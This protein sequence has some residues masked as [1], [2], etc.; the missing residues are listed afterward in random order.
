[1]KQ[2][3]LDLIRHSFLGWPIRLL[4]R[5]TWRH[6]RLL[7]LTNPFFLPSI[8]INREGTSLLAEPDSYLF[9]NSEKENYIRFRPGQ[10]EA[11]ITYLS[12]NLIEKTDIVLDIGANVGLHTVAFAREASQGHVYAFEPTTEMTERLSANVSLNGIKNVTIVPCALG[13]AEEELEMFINTSGAGLE[14][15]STITGTHNVDRNP[16]NYETR[17]V[18]VRRLDYLVEQ[19]GIKGRIGFIKID[20]EGYETWVIEGGLNTIRAH[21]PTMIVEAHSRRLTA[22]NKSFKWYLD[23]FPDYHILIIYPIDRT[24]PYL[25]LVPL[26]EEQPEMA[27]NLLMLPRCKIAATK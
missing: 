6:P 15:T 1:M 20:T 10:Y 27:I 16:L 8:V 18:P 22:A 2:I 9:L 3:I 4:G 26:T 5:F 14:G 13:A 12:K 7:T 21:R 11:E 24:N 19:L 17:K 25:R 23:M